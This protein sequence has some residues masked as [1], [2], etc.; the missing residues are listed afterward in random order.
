MPST[1]VGARGNVEDVE[2]FVEALKAEASSRGLQAQAFNADMVF[3]EDHLLSAWEHAER[4]FQRGTNVATDPMVEVL[5]Y[6]AGDRQIGR[7]IERMGIKKGKGPIV[8]L[9]V[10]EG[11][12]AGLPQGVPTGS[13]GWMHSPTSQ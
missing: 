5:L 7:A 12:E 9:V 4:A 3:G 1:V 2:G 6:A 13:S 10:G 11:E 8:L